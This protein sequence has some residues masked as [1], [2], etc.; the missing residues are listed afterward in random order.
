MSS[1]PAPVVEAGTYR[2][3]NVGSGLVLEVYGAAKGSGARVQQGRE[4]AGAAAHQ[5]WRLSPVHEGASL[6]HLVNAHSDKRLDVAGAD[7]ENGVR[8]QQWKAN[9]FGAQEW[10]IEQHPEAPGTV[11]L[12]SFVSG[13]VMEVADGSTEEG[14]TVQQWEDTDSPFQWWRLEPVSS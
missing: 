1:D 9:N 10:L 5:R 6:Y 11:T 7:T 14:G 13:L 12:V 4:E 2:L 8:I 3:R